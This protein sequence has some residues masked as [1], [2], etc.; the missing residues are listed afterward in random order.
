[1]RPLLGVILAAL[2]ALL[3]VFAFTGGGRQLPRMA[4]A[5]AAKPKPVLVQ[6]KGRT[7]KGRRCRNMT[8]SA[9]GY[10]YLHHNQGQASEVPRP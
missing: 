7:V 5:L 10:C 2:A 8:R 3:L 4:E 9:D 6:C 1:M